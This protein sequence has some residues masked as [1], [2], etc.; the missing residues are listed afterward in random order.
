[1]IVNL[2]NCCEEKNEKILHRIRA[3]NEF[4]WNGERKVFQK[5]TE[6]TPNSRFQCISPLKNSFRSEGETFLVYYLRSPISSKRGLPKRYM[7]RQTRFVSQKI[8]FPSNRDNVV[9]REYCSQ[10]TVVKFWKIHHCIITA[11]CLW[12]RVIKTSWIREV[13]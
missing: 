1:M 5:Q 2:P 3:Q 4:L 6:N 8:L 11:F 9:E 13:K 12:I 10:N 7:A